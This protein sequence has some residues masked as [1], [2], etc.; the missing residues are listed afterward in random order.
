ME[1]ESQSE[2]EDNS[3]TPSISCLLS[4]KSEEDEK[5]YTVPADES[6]NNVNL[7]TSLSPIL[8]SESDVDLNK[9]LDF[10]ISNDEGT[11]VDEEVRPN[12]LL[13]MGLCMK[14]ITPNRLYKNEYN[15]IKNSSIADENQAEKNTNYVTSN[16]ISNFEKNSSIIMNNKNNLDSRDLQNDTKSKNYVASVFKNYKDL[17]EIY[18]AKLDEKKKRKNELHQY[19]KEEDTFC[20]NDEKINNLNKVKD[21]NYVYEKDKIDVKNYHS[22]FDM[23]NKTYSNENFIEDNIQNINQNHENKL[24]NLLDQP[25]YKL[26]PNS[27]L[28]IKTSSSHTTYSECN[29]SQ[30]LTHQNETNSKYKLTQTD[31]LYS[32]TNMHLNDSSLTSSGHYLSNY[33]LPGTNIE[34]NSGK[35]IER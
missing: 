13:D 24:N 2:N 16:S 17:E 14:S 15:E 34:N 35:F 5:K 33:I 18:C 32:N 9:F 10:D 27:S 12:D 22:E 6:P 4:D 20:V 25:P 30:T 29:P 31:S 19:K 3:S 23:K 28:L 21:A 1:Q 11:I 26:L 7:L 8:S